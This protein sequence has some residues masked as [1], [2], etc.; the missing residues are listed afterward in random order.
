MKDQYLDA[1][2]E[3]LNEQQSNQSAD[4]P[5]YKSM[6]PADVEPL[7]IK[8]PDKFGGNP[9]AYKL[10]HNAKIQ[11]IAALIEQMAQQL[12]NVR[13]T[14][15]YE[16]ERYGPSVA[17]IDSIGKILEQE[18]WSRAEIIEAAKEAGYVI[19]PGRLIKMKKDAL[20][21]K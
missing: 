3:F 13:A 4:Q 17:S 8:D 19:T 11:V 20:P 18:T 9:D 21:P 14:W 7:L 2:R 5:A 1:W 10:N 6:Q 12:L 16:Y 15:P